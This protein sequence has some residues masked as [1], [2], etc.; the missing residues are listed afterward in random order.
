LC[1]FCLKTQS[2]L[3]FCGLFFSGKQKIED[4]TEDKIYFFILMH[5]SLIRLISNWIR[6]LGVLMNL[7]LKNEAFLPHNMIPVN[8]D[9]FHFFKF[10]MAPR[11]RLLMS[12]G[13]KKEPRYVCLTEPK[14]LLAHTTWAEVLSSAPHLHKKI[15][16]SPIKWSC[17]LSVLFPVSRPITTLH[18]VLSK[19]MALFWI[20]CRSAAYEARLPGHPCSVPFAKKL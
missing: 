9:P 7:G 12:F 14:A 11:I 20:V 16:I 10:Q 19:D 4:N 6:I 2:I 3:L 13:P 8:G 18:C 17:I 15:L 5:D 1:L